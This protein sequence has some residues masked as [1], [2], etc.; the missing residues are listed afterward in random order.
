MIQCHPPCRGDY[1]GRRPVHIAAAF[2][3]MKALEYL[4][5]QKRADV[6]V[7]DRVGCTPLQ[8]AVQNLHKEAAWFLQ[9]H[10]AELQLVNEATTL[11][12]LVQEYTPQGR[13]QLCRY[14][15]LL[16]HKAQRNG[17]ERSVMTSNE[18]SQRNK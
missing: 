10:G 16:V 17:T 11:C 14:L 15:F 1:D 13:G 9:R 12:N 3:Q 4:V 7:K 5:I 8:D 6:N 2:G 18:W